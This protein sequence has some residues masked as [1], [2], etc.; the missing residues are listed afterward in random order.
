MN[1]FL[2][3]LDFVTSLN[4]FF[5]SFSILVHNNTI[6]SLRLI[7]S[8]F[9]KTKASPFVRYLSENIRFIFER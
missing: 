6:I 5:R 1:M 8:D 2:W 9:S 3:L 4:N 7:L